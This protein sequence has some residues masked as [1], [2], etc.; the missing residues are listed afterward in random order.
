MLSLLPNNLFGCKVVGCRNIPKQVITSTDIQSC[1]TEDHGT[2][3]IGIIDPTR[4]D[5]N[6]MAARMVLVLQQQGK[7]SPCLLWL[8]EV[9]PGLRWEVPPGSF[10]NPTPDTGIHQCHKSIHRE[11]FPLMKIALGASRLP[12]PFGSF[13]LTKGH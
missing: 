12:K 9:Y 7:D 10:Q 6:G 13:F 5:G 2:A 1:L 11:S 4:M 8:L 3:K